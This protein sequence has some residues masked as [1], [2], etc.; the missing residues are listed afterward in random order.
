MAALMRG[1]DTN[2]VIRFLVRDDGPQAVAAKAA[3]D[4][5][6]RAGERL[7]LG[8]LAVL[9]IEWVLR[10]RYGFGKGTILRTFRALLEARELA[11]EAEETLEHALYLFENASADFADCLLLARYLRLGCDRM[12]T[13]DAGAAKLPGCELLGA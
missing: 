1:L 11:F 4:A 6:I 9:E 7:M 13:F 10:S 12:L 8:L 2:V 5:A 3:V